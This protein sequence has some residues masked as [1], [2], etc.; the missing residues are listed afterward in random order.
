[1]TS[2]PPAPAHVVDHLTPKVWRKANRLLVRKALSE[3]AHERILE[4]QLDTQRSARHEGHCCY[5]LATPAGG[6]VYRFEARLMALH[7]WAIDA[8]SIDCVVGGEPR[9]LDALHFM[10]DF[11]QA[12]GLR[13]EQ[14]PIYLDEICSTL[15]SSAYKHLKSAPDS[16]ALIDADF[17]AVETSMIEGHP[18]FVANNG[19]LGFDGTDYRAYAP[20]A[21][22]PFSIVWLAVHKDHAAFH[23]V[24]DLSYEQLL[25]EELGEETLSRFHAVLTAQGLATDDYLVMPAHPW[26]W[27]NKL[28]VA[29]APYVAQQRIVFL[30]TS[31]DRYLAQQSIRTMY[32]ISEPHKRY[33]KTSL[34][35]LNMGFMRGLSPY[36][37][38]GTPAI[39]QWIKDLIDHD[40]E[41]RANGFTILREVASMGF[42][43]HY[44]EAAI[45]AD[46]PYKKMFS[47]LWREN[48][49][50]LLKPG[51]RLMTMAS[52]L[53]TDRDGQPLLPVLIEASGLSPTAWLHR[54]LQTYLTPLIHCFYAHDLVF[55]PHGE[56]LILVMDGHVPVRVIMKD[57]AEETALFNPDVELPDNIRRLIMDFPDELKTLAV[58]IDIF[59]G[60][61]RYMNQILVEHG[62]CTEHDFWRAV[63]D[64]I[65]AYQDEH[66][67]YR[68]KFARYDLFAPSFAQ[69]CLNRLQMGN[70][71]QMINLA[72]PSANLKIVGT[73]ANPLAP[74]AP[75]GPA[76]PRAASQPLAEVAP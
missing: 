64:N 35:I 73:M 24:P 14:L 18:A 32:N 4:P 52:L 21:A 60:F 45:E 31:A 69:S 30:G 71:T 12:L 55:M 68:D 26:Q 17:Q 61:F 57:I 63:A 56:N 13:P 33:V 8:S 46:S 15:Y 10:I 2:M 40:T 47:A 38:S 42:R 19:R 7:H 37:M 49:L 48:P 6:T 5:T 29:F 62:V 50:P 58:F 22:A 11:K 28:S 65:R 44:Y 54:Y 41:L 43:N 9:E 23:C 76:T 34:S 51:E 72:D 75:S 1:M 27:A 74:F 36:Y 70:N 53:H 66:P 25:R 20:E 3:F 39:N 67:Q 16:R 59:D